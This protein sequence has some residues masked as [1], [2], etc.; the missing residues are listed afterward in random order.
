MDGKRPVLKAQAD[1]RSIPIIALTAHAMIKAGKSARVDD[2][3][4][5]P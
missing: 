5:K 3:L 4:I 2:F 1:L